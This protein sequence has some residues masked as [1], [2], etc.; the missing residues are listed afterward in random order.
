MNPLH[1]IALPLAIAVLSACNRGAVPPE[2]QPAAE[3][4]LAL[5]DQGRYAESWTEAGARFKELVPSN[6]WERQLTGV[7]SPLGALQAR[8]RT[9]ATPTTKLPGAPDGE[10]VVFQFDASFANKESAVE[11]ATVSKETD[12]AWRVSGYYIH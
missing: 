8:K 6:V 9:S 5:V 1:V 12:G 4:W 3:R 10:Y 7:R 2:A 11:T